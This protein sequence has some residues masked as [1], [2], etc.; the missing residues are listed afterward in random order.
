MINSEKLTAEY[1]IDYKCGAY[2]TMAFD[3]WLF[4]RLRNQELSAGIILRLYTWKSGAITFGYNQDSGKAIDMSLLSRETPVIRRITGGRAIYHDP[5]EF[6][7]SLIANLEKIDGEQRS[8]ATLNKLTSESIID[9]LDKIGV[10]AGWSRNSPRHFSRD[11]ISGRKSCFDSVTRYEIA[12]GKSKIAGLAQRRTGN[13]AIIQGSLKINGVSSC[14]AIGQIE[15][16]SPGGE[17]KLDPQGP[18]N[19]G[20]KKFE[21]MLVKAFTSRF[22]VDFIPGRLSDDDRDSLK[23]ASRNIEKKSFKKR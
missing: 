19:S 15:A 6:T 10:Q 11:T 4:T 22:G 18:A 3:E 1:F 5:S 17:Y 12:G 20:I 16:P 7:I 13:F 2:F 23:I 14:P 21:N 8:F 9:T